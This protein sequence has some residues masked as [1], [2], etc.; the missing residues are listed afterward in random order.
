MEVKVSKERFTM[1][2]DTQM[3]ELAI[4]FNDGKLELEKLTDMVSYA[5]LILDRLHEHG[6][7]SKTS[8]KEFNDGTVIEGK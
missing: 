2:T 5:S 4:L 7:I 6:N 8:S 3:I 1:P